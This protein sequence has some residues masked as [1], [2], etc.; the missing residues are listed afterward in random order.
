MA[1]ILALTCV[2]IY[3]ASAVLCDLG[4]WSRYLAMAR[5]LATYF[6][7]SSFSCAFPEGDN[8]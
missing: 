7:L 1:V 4:A 6:V 3:L 2:Y 5:E 8:L